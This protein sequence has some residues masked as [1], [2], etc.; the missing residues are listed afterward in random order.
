MGNA[1]FSGMFLNQVIKQP[2]GISNVPKR[3]FCPREMSQNELN[4]LERC[5]PPGLP[6]SCWLFSELKKGD[7]WSLFPLQH[8]RKLNH[9]IRSTGSNFFSFFLTSQWTFMPD[10]FYASFWTELWLQKNVKKL[11]VE[12]IRNCHHQKSGGIVDFFLGHNSVQKVATFGVR[13]CPWMALRGEKN[14]LGKKPSLRVAPNKLHGEEVRKMSWE[15]RTQ[16]PREMLPSHFY[17]EGA[18]SKCLTFSFRADVLQ[19]GDRG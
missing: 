11:E 4:F 19:R 14:V 3:T 15:K 6:G 9:S 10:F 18:L 5:C 2:T 13:D 8:R 1:L 7:F 16:F 17:W 12:N